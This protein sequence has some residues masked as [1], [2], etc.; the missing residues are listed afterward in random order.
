M[1]LVFTRTIITNYEPL[2]I[3]Q[4]GVTIWIRSDVF[5]LL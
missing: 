2:Y 3:V 5:I 1:F 4:D